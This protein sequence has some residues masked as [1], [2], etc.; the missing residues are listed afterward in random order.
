VRILE[1]CP[2]DLGRP[3]GVQ[4]QVQLLAGAL[5]GLG[6][7]VALLGP[8]PG[9]LG[10]SRAIRANGSVA[11]IA[12]GP[13]MAGTL[14]AGLAWAEVVHLHEPLVPLV[15]PLALELARRARVPVVATGHRAGASPQLRTLL[16]VLGDAVAPRLAGTSAVSPVAAELARLWGRREP[17][18]VPNGVAVPR[19]TPRERDWSRVLFVGR[20]EE[21][22]GIGVLLAALE[23]LAGCASEVVIVGNGP[24]AG[25]VRSA[26]ARWRTLVRWDG[27]LD[28]TGLEE[29]FAR[30]GILV[31]PSLGGESFGV[32]L[33][34]AMARGLA[35][36]A[37]D[38]PGYRA[39]VDRAAV[40]VPP[41]DP[42]SLVRAVCALADDPPRA[43][44]LSRAGRR[45]AEGF[46]I[47]AVARRYREL[48]EH[49]V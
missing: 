32:I 8:G 42:R 40:L 43:E 17:R 37:S 1:I 41:G 11:P 36:V 2:Y 38:I 28:D 49:V 13:R 47:E 33:V 48:F 31:A 4:R 45:R 14:A 30:A 16:R 26:R 9:G 22:K 6:D 35:V 3:G 24:L 5:E 18:I 29:A 19:E 46:A 27:G 20:L 7:E 39:L 25:A 10:P 23:G 34:E 15:G 44:E 21:R 12:I